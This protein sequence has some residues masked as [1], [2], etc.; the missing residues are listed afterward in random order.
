MD[1]LVLFEE[2]FAIIDTLI[3]PEFSVQLMM[4]SSENERICV[5]EL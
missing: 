5:R 2:A 3:F 4:I 1:S